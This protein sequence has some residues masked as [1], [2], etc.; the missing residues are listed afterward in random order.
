[1]KNTKPFFC[2]LLMIAITGI[3]FNKC[4]SP[5]KLPEKTYVH[6][7]DKGNPGLVTGKYEPAYINNFSPEEYE[8]HF[9]KIFKGLLEEHNV[10]LVGSSSEK[11]DY[12][13][14][15]SRMGLVE[16]HKVDEID[17]MKSKYN[18]D[19][20]RLSE[21]EAEVKIE[22]FLGDHIELKDSWEVDE[23]KDDELDSDKRI[24]EFINDESEDKG[25]YQAT[26]MEKDV[27][28]ELLGEL[29]KKANAR[30]TTKMYKGQ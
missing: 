6:V 12:T 1:M 9:F 11:I 24:D 16:I 27:F 7:E 4:Y 26:N 10:I 8:D 22:L 21:C 25:T 17:E 28:K 15:I 29:A 13:V 23:N 19:K 18:G 5:K 20:Y 3:L 30:V 2:S 14:S